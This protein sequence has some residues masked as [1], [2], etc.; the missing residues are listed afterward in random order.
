[1]SFA[2]FVLCFLD[3]PRRAHSSATSSS[4]HSSRSES[5]I[6]FIVYYRPLVVFLFGNFC[7]IGI[8]GIE[9]VHIMNLY[10]RMCL[11]LGSC[12]SQFF[13]LS[14]SRNL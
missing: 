7:I 5:S 13:L 9:S 14:F 3:L 2:N 10:R 6:S 4:S 11:L 8:F 1:M 12:C